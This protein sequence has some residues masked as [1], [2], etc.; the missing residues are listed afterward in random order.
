MSVSL[1]AA[2]EEGLDEAQDYVTEL[3]M[4]TGFSPDEEVLV[5]GAVRTEEYD[6][7]AMQVI[8]HVVLRNR[9]HDPASGTH[10]F[11]DWDALSARIARFVSS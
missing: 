4:R 9:D 7:F 11:T 5:A 2:F 6:Y 3:K 8:R 1:N 10:E